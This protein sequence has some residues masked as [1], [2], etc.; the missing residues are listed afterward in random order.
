MKLLWSFTH[1]HVVSNLYE[2][3]SSAEHIR[4]YFEELS[5]EGSIL[6]MATSNCVWLPTLIL[7]YVLLS[8]SEERKSYRF[9]TSG[10]WINDDRIW[11]SCWTIPLIKVFKNPT[12]PEL[13][14][15][16]L[17]N[18]YLVVSHLLSIL[19]LLYATIRLSWSLRMEQHLWFYYISIHT[20]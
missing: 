17:C 13:F 5:V 4:R 12:V 11:I 3:H 10:G 19:A 9:E 14:N 18:T 1:P 8:S 6:T 16:F 15:I 20:I 2:F 7:K